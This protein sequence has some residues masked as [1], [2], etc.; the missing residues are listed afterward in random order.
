M[1]QSNKLRERY[2]I[3]YKDEIRQLF[4]EYDTVS[5]NEYLYEKY[6]NVLGSSAKEKSEIINIRKEYNDLFYN[7]YNNE[8]V[9]KSAF[10]N[11]VLLKKAGV[12]IFE[13]KS[14][15]SRLDLCTINGES[16]AFEVKT[17]LDTFDRLDKQISDYERLFD[18]TYV[19]CSHDRLRDIIDIVNDTCGIYL[20]KNQRGKFRFKVYKQAK[21]SAN[22][23]P[24]YQLK[25]MTLG[26]LRRLAN[27]KNF[28][29][30][31]CL[32]FCSTHLTKKSINRIFKD[33]LK[34]KYFDSWEFL[35]QNSDEIV[36]IDYQWFFKN[37]IQPKN[38][39]R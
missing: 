19:I 15:G 31:Q 21:K 13:L 8:S 6:L 26:Y 11:H 25:I 22:L 16:T 32:E 27:N 33:Y 12:T 7:F 23:D 36:D 28:S 3:K 30:E 18:K 1:M 24:G 10:I 14:G 29:R 37:N 38:I 9:I 2:E 4:K 39:Y 20:Y 34:F 17:D 35:K 5:L